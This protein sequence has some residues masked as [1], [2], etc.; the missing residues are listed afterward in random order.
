MRYYLPAKEF[1]GLGA[2]GK[3]PDHS[4]LS[5]FKRRMWIEMRIGSG[6]RGSCRGI[7]V[8]RCAGGAGARRRRMGA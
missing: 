3:G 5:L 8:R 1:V 2:N 6:R 4:T 7:G